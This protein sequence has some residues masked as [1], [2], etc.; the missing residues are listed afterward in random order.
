MNRFFC[1]L[2]L[3]LATP[4][5]A[6]LP[7]WN[8]YTNGNTVSAILDAGDKLWL[9]TLGSGLIEFTKATGQKIFYTRTNS[10]IPDDW[11]AAMVRD[12]SNR[13]WISTRRGVAMFDGKNWAVHDTFPDGGKVPVLTVLAANPDNSLWGV[14]TGISRYG[15]LK[16]DGTQWSRPADTSGFTP[17]IVTYSVA[18]AKDSVVW[19]GTEASWLTFFNGKKWVEG[20]TGDAF[21]VATDW[22]GGVWFANN[23][24][25]LYKT[26]GTNQTSYSLEV[27]GTG[28]A[29]QIYAA[30]PNRIII[31]GEVDIGT[32]THHFTMFD[33]TTLLPYQN[34]R[35]TPL[36]CVTAAANGDL[37]FGT[38]N[39]FARFRNGEWEFVELGLDNLPS[40]QLNDVLRIGSVVWVAGKGGLTRFDGTAWTTLDS[41]AIGIGGEHVSLSPDGKGGFWTLTNEGAAHFDG[42]AWNVVP[43][44][45]LLSTAA[46][47]RTI[48][49]DNS[50]T[51]WIGTS[52]AG[53]IKYN[54]TTTSRYTPP[55]LSG[56]IAAIDLDT[57][58]NV[59]IGASQGGISV[60]VAATAQFQQLNQANSK[61][62]SNRVQTVVSD[63][64]DG[65]W[66]GTS[67]GLV[68]FSLTSQTT[69]QN[70]PFTN[71]FVRSVKRAPDG[72]LWLITGDALHRFD[73]TRW[74]AKFTS[75]NSGFV[76]S[77]KMDIGVDGDV[78][79]ATLSSGLTRYDARITTDVKSIPEL[80]NRLDLR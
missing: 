80:P 65:M 13:L 2:F 17:Q 67:V 34:P 15:V 68:K 45:T 35:G 56:D 52:N 49:A 21:W 5:A 43:R 30:S 61:L 59:W 55:G 48:T 11:I 46:T 9:G 74:T 1:L 77:G 23:P 33:G 47:L 44:T 62:P 51:I 54:G 10:G 73:G 19:V 20:A 66:I 37:Y 28:F 18:A 22:D 12:S 75:S 50:G 32:T 42:S 79:I 3:V 63:G 39:G 27:P 64:S 41:T 29:R 58:G 70:A 69:F 57:A 6:Q 78:W 38:N 72:A 7:G 53:V 25:I 4:V 60:L 14:A 26:N 31:L 40:N 71:P 24:A 16:F 76:E 8:H 36:L